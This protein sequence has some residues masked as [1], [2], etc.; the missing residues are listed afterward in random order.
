MSQIIETFEGTLKRGDAVLFT[1]KE[2]G[3]E[4]YKESCSLFQDKINKCLTD[5]IEAL[6]PTLKVSKRTPDESES[7]SSM[8]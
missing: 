3:S 1:L 6:P 7:E 5:Q 8:E 4:N 2:E